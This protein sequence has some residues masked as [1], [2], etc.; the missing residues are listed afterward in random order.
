MNTSAATRSII[1]A[2]VVTV[3]LLVAGAPAYPETTCGADTCVVNNVVQTPAGPVTVNV[4]TDNIVTVHL[5]PVAA[6]T[7]VFGLPFQYPPA[8]ASAPG[9]TRVSMATASAGT[10]NIDTILSPPGPPTRLGVPT[11]VIIS[12][13]P[14]NPCR[15][16]TIGSTVTFTPLSST[17]STSTA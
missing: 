6:N 16:R 1:A 3:S 2:A 11:I 14:P 4:T 17:R 8:P 10:V 5:T 9:Y 12:I 7:I 13:H 15:S